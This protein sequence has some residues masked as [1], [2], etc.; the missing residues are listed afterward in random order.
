MID[1]L[2]Y[3]RK[4]LIAALP[5]IDIYDIIAEENGEPPYAVVN[6]ASYTVVDGSCDMIN[7]KVDFIMFDLYGRKGHSLPLDQLSDQV[8]TVLVTG[9][10]SLTIDNYQVTKCTIIN[11]T[12]DG[13]LLFNRMMYRRTFKFELLLS[14]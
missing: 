13:V 1:P 2:R 6:L 9:E 12:S 8:L 10:T 5:G 11:S 7:A 14:T 4:G 3:I